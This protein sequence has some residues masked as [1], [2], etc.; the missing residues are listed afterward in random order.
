MKI[1]KGFFK[2]LSRGFSVIEEF[3]Q[4]I[5]HISGY[6]LELNRGLGLTFGVQFQHI[7]P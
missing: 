3:L 6:L 2:I 7:L 5:G 4:C 1:F